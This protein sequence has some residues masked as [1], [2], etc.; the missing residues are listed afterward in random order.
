[1]HL[2]PSYFTRLFTRSF[3]IPPV[4]YILQARIQ[5]AQM[6]LRQ[7]NYTI[8]NIGAN[9]GFLDRF[10]FS[11]TFKNIT[12]TSPGIYRNKLFQERP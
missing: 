12:G 5:Q 9:L 11:R 8:E 6:L 2:E 1:M 4:H 3:G 10:H 7:T